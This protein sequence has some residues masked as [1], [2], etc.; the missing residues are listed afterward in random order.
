LWLCTPTNLFS[1]TNFICW[2]AAFFFPDFR[3]N[4]QARTLVPSSLDFIST[5]ISILSSRAHN[6]NT[7][8]VRHTTFV[9]HQ[10]ECN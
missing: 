9:A 8:M 7:N 10:W 3:L 2:L 1:S 5:S 4:G 6:I